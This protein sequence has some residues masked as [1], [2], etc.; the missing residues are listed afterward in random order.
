MIYWF[1]MRNFTQN[2]YQALEEQKIIS[3]AHWQEE[4]TLANHANEKALTVCVL[5]KIWD[6]LNRSLNVFFIFLKNSYFSKLIMDCKFGPTWKLFI[7]EKNLPKKTKND[8]QLCMN[9]YFHSFCSS[10]SNYNIVYGWF[11]YC[12]PS[13]FIIQF[14]DM[15]DNEFFEEWNIRYLLKI[16]KTNHS[17]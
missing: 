5:F 13:K 10:I 17:Y 2:R 15:N 8:H 7:Y 4:L 1:Y 3:D 6:K 11:V 14:S 12:I 9:F 16:I